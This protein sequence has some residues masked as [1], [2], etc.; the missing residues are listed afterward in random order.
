MLRFTAVTLWGEHGQDFSRPAR[1][2][3]M[4]QGK[5]VCGIDRSADYTTGP[6]GSLSRGKSA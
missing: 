4:E 2:D 1:P 3:R 5:C 6:T